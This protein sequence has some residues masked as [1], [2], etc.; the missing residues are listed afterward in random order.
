[1]SDKDIVDNSRLGSRVGIN[2]SQ[3]ERERDVI[4]TEGKR[5]K[6][7]EDDSTYKSKSI[8]TLSL[9]LDPYDP[10]DPAKNSIRFYLQSISGDA[11]LCSTCS[12]TATGDSTGTPSLLPGHFN[13]SSTRYS[14]D[15]ISISAD[16]PLNCARAGRSGVFYIGITGASDG[17]NTFSLTA[18]KYGG[19]RTVIPGMAI[20]GKVLAGL[21][22]LYRFQL[23]YT[24]AQ[25]VRIT[26]TPILGDVDLFVKLGKT[27]PKTK[28]NSQWY[29]A[30][31]INSVM[32]T[33]SSIGIEIESD[34]TVLRSFDSE[35]GSESGSG[36]GS[37]SDEAP[38]DPATRTHYDYMSTDLYSSADTVTVSE[39]DMA[40]CAA[41]HCWVS[42]LVDGYSTADYTL[43]VTLQ[44]TVIQLQDGVP[45]HSSVTEVG[46]LGCVHKK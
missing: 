3:G 20:K 15:F 7:E 16:Y 17:Q 39:A 44:D 5:V 26:V 28:I 35:S 8:K 34:S 46:V 36:S 22:D 38:Y 43:L 6:E 24:T 11:D 45:Q 37:P 1:M 25:Q 23:P 18:L 10:S 9:D 29:S 13:F 31:N 2:I 12:L 21:G 27:N 32:E 41:S 33:D 40:S 4:L 30:L 42:I 19:L 14:D